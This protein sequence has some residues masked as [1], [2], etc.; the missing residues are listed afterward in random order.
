MFSSNYIMNT[1]LKVSR[2]FTVSLQCHSLEYRGPI[3]LLIFNWNTQLR[4]ATPL[5]PCVGKIVVRC[6]LK[7]SE[8]KENGRVVV[9]IQMKE[10]VPGSVRIFCEIESRT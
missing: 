10:L 1:F 7:G 5:C 3:A 2:F 9:F 8:R 4:Y 6:M